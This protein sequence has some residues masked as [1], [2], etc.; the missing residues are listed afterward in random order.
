MLCVYTNNST[1]R[2]TEPHRAKEQTNAPKTHTTNH[3]KQQ[4]RQPLRSFTQRRNDRKPTERAAKA[5]EQRRKPERLHHRSKSKP[6]KASDRRSRTAYPSGH[7]NRA[8]TARTTFIFLFYKFTFWVFSAAIVESRKDFRQ[9]SKNFFQSDSRKS[10]NSRKSNKKT[11]SGESRASKGQTRSKSNSRKS[12]LN[13]RIS[14]NFA[15][16]HR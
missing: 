7:T 10:I 5:Q 8:N 16:A 15:K 6:N 13:L 14:L 12:R 2:H 3:K 1:K 11:K 4:H 9:I